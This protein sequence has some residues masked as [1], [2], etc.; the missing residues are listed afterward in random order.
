MRLW[1]RKNMHQ[2][3][4]E[5]FSEYLDGRL[6]A[7]M[8]AW[9]EAHLQ[10]CHPCQDELASV[11]A[12]VQLVRM[13]PQAPAPRSFVLRP[14]QVV[15]QVRMRVPFWATWLPA[16]RV[17]TAATAAL[18]L[19]VVSVDVFGAGGGTTAQ[20]TSYPI[21]RSQQQADAPLQE[22]QRL[23]PAA[24]PAP[25]QPS[26][27]QGSLQDGGGKA[28]AGGQ[29]SGAASQ[30]M[31]EASNDAA[32]GKPSTASAVRLAEAILFTV[33]LLL[34]ACVLVMARRRQPF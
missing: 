22:K 20:T 10:Q 29:S 5:A 18:F 25:S 28:Q 3:A 32:A 16:L 31:S 8:A 14:E 1:F 19:V 9:L 27:S 33:S 21:L 17:A 15:Q 30:P 13:M 6:S 4:R 23:A 12:A 11:R 2:Q 24:A 7:G 34:L 26:S